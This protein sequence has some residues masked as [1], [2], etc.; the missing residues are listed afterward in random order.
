MLVVKKSEDDPREIIR[1]SLEVAERNHRNILQ[2][3]R[4]VRKKRA[5]E[6]F[7]NRALA[8][9]FTEKQALFLLNE[10]AHKDHSHSSRM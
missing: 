4:E 8:S 1:T 7:V 2:E 6:E 5:N 10:L 9:V 3:M